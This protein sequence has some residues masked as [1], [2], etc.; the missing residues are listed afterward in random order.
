M[1][2]GLPLSVIVSKNEE[3]SLVIDINY[4]SFHILAREPQK[5]VHLLESRIYPGIGNL[6]K[7]KVISSGAVLVYSFLMSVEWIGRPW[8]QLVSSL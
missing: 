8:F 1:S 6:S 3:R 7:A 2:R 4:Q 5:K